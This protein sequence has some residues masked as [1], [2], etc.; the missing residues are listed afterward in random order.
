M[1]SARSGSS[2]CDSEVAEFRAIQGGVATAAHGEADVATRRHRHVGAARRGPGRAVDALVG[3]D[4]VADAHQ[5][6]PRIRGRAGADG[7]G[8]R[9][10]PRGDA[11]RC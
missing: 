6:Y 5:S 3:R 1:A 9:Y 10:S 7:A 11:I 2:W 4:H 8:R